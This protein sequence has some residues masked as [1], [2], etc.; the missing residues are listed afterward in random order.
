MQTVGEDPTLDYVTSYVCCL[1]FDQ[2]RRQ[3]N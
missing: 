3:I 2:L 1:T